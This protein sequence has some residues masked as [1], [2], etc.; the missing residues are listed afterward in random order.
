MDLNGRRNSLV[1][2]PRS[3]WLHPNCFLTLCHSDH[4][5]ARSRDRDLDW[6]SLQNHTEWG[7]GSYRKIGVLFWKKEKEKTEIYCRNKKIVLHRFGFFFKI[8]R[9]NGSKMFSTMSDT[10]KVFDNYLCCCFEWN[11]SWEG[12]WKIQGEKWIKREKDS[13]GGLAGQRRASSSPWYH[14]HL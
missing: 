11:R 1:I 13:T 3:E 12:L 5:W 10:Q 14:D 9:C 6:Q 8:K 7:R 4:T 2:I